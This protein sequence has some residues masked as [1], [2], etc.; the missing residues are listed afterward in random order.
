MEKKRSLKVKLLIVSQYF[1]PENFKINDVAKYFQSKK[2]DVT[3]I[4]GYPNYPEGKIFKNFFKKKIFYSNYLGSIKII[5]VP[6]FPRG[7]NKFFLFCNY[8]SFLISACVFVA[9]NLKKLNFDAI[10]CFGTSPITSA[11]PG[12]LISKLKKKPLF[13]WVLDLWP[14]TLVDLK[15]IKSP[16]VLKL[17]NHVVLFIYKNCTIVFGQSQSIVKE[18][19]KKITNVKKT[20]CVYLPSWYESFFD[21]KKEEKICTKKIF[22]IMY[23]GNIGD[24]QDYKTIISCA[25]RLKNFNDIC[26]TIVGKGRKFNIFI[27]ELKN[28]NIF[29]NFKFLGI[30]SLN[31]MPTIYSKSDILI[32]TLKSG[33]ALSKTIPSRLQTCLISRKPIVAAATGEVSRIIKI[34]KSGLACNSGNFKSLS[35]NI[36]KLKNSS[37]TKRAQYGKN[38]YNYAKK[39]FNRDKVLEILEKNIITNI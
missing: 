24:A 25:I 17:I 12:V 31:K 28:K 8:L 3:V 13:L 11:I 23:A 9:C 15:V 5:R 2:N 6:I 38:G 26:W 18:I 37:I 10:F 4:T 20:K 21:K 1:W 14:E 22:N 7:N 29:N 16:I 33:M 34:S 39:N 27:K 36:L 35:E 30:K 32:I 19:K